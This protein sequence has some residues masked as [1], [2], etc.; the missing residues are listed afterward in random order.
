[1]SAYCR[2]TLQFARLTTINRPFRIYI[3]IFRGHFHFLDPHTD[4]YNGTSKRGTVISN[5]NK[6][7]TK[8]STKKYLTGN[9]PKQLEDKRNRPLGA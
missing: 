4:K 5:Y 2:I 7:K 6:I 3:P 8:I 9:I 1:M